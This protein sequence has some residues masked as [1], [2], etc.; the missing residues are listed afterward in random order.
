MISCAR[1]LKGHPY[2]FSFLR[3][4]LVTLTSRKGY[5]FVF[6]H[7]Q[8]SLTPQVLLS[9]KHLLCM[10]VTKLLLLL[11]KWEFACSLSV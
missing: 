3:R 8:G 9:K 11:G 6:F 1:L 5:C 4:R 10:V 7:Y 2:P